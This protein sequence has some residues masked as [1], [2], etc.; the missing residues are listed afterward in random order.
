MKFKYKDQIV[1]ASSKDEAIKLVVAKVSQETENF[2]SEMDSRFVDYKGKVNEENLRLEVRDFVD[3]N[4]QIQNAMIGRRS[5]T[6]SLVWLGLTLLCQDAFKDANGTKSSLTSDKIKGW[7][8]SHNLDYIKVLKPLVDEVEE[9]RVDRE[10]YEK[11]QKSKA[12]K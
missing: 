11:K 2:F 7:F 3:S 4:Q 6:H 10:N 5:K 8:K 1:T 12:G 9:E